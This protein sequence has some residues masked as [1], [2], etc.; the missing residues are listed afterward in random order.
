MDERKTAWDRGIE[1]GL[2]R[3]LA[4]GARGVEQRLEVLE[5]HWSLEGERLLDV[6]C[7][8][9]SYTLRLARRFE[10][11]YGIDLEPDRLR[12]F[13]ERR[14]SQGLKEVVVQQMSAEALAFPPDC[15][16]AVTA[17]EVIEHILHLEEAV[18]EIFRVLK[19]GGAFLLTCP[20]RGFPFETHWVFVGRRGLHGKY[21]PFLPYVRPLHRRWARARNFTPRDL[22][23]LL[24]PVGFERVAVDYVMPPFDNWRFGTRFLKPLTDRLGRTA[25]RRLG[26]SVAGVYR[27]PESSPAGRDA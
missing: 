27:K 15:F 4:F 9:G 19:P 8:N 3:P 17:I 11:T 12:E 24:L 23:E 26:V 7:G 21:L 13:E 22:D 5:R 1:V 14:R 16:E 10:A 6:G 18:K 25:L 20:N 2:G